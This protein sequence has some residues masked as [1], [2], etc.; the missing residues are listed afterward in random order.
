MLYFLTVVFVA[1][2]FQLLLLAANK[3]NWYECC[4]LSD[5]ERK[6][7]SFM[8]YGLSTVWFISVPIVA[9]IAAVEIVKWAAVKWLFK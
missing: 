9:A 1:I 7:L 3:Y 5:V 6:W 8:G 2:I 4:D